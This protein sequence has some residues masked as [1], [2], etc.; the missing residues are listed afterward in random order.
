[1]P[2]LSK[3]NLRG[4]GIE[5][6]ENLFNRHGI[7]YRVE[8]GSLIFALRP[9]D[10]NP[11]C[12]AEKHRDGGW[13]DFGT[14][15]TGDAY[16]LIAK[17]HNL[18]PK[19]DFQRIL[20]LAYNFLG[21][22][23]PQDSNGSNGHSANGNGSGKKPLK[24]M[25]PEPTQDEFLAQYGLEKSDFVKANAR[26]QD[27]VYFSDIGKEVRAIIYDI[28]L[29]DGRTTYK[30][31]S[32]GR[33]TGGSRLSTAIKS[34]IGFHKGFF[35][36]PARAAGKHLVIAGGEEKRMAAE[37]AG[38]IAVCGANGE[39]KLQAETLEW[40]LKIAPS[41]ITIAFDADAPGYK[42]TSEL[43]RQLK[44]A[45]YKG[46]VRVISWPA[47]TPE[48]HDINDILKA[49]GIIGVKAHINGA[50][51][52]NEEEALSQE[53]VCTDIANAIRFADKFHEE[54]TFNRDVEHW[55]TYN[56]RH[57]TRDVGSAKAMRYATKVP[58]IILKEAGKDPAR[59]DMLGKWAVK[60]AMLPRLKALLEIARTDEKIGCGSDD[61]DKNH[62]DF[63]VRNGTID[64]RTGELR[65]HS[66]DDRIT[67][68]GNALYDPNADCPLWKS[69][70]SQI[71]GGNQDLIAFLQ[72]AVGYAMTGLTNEQCLFFLYGTGSNGKTTFLETIA[73]L[74]GDYAQAGRPESFLLDEHGGSTGSEARPDLV[75]LVGAR[76]V[77][78]TEVAKGRRLDEATVKALTG[79]DTRLIRDLYKP[80]FE[81]KPTLKLFM[82]ANH[83]PEIHG[84]DE[85]IWRRIHMIPFTVTFTDQQ[86]DE[87]LPEKLREEGPGILNWA[88]AGAKA[89]FLQKLD[90]PKLVKAA[91]NQYREES[92]ILSGFLRERCIVGNTFQET[93]AS[94]YAA[95]EEWCKTVGEQAVKQKTF[96]SNLKEKGF[97]NGRLNTGARGWFGIRLRK[98]GEG[99]QREQPRT[100][101]AQENHDLFGRSS[102]G[103]PMNDGEPFPKQTS[104]SGVTD[105]WDAWDASP[106]ETREN[107]VLDGLADLDGSPVK[108]HTCARN[109][110]ELPEYASKSVNASNPSYSTPSTS[111]G[112]TTDPDLDAEDLAYLDEERRAIMDD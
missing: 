41:E 92:D 81:W 22:P 52:F 87:R 106:Q 70:L 90:P 88:L 50:I 84:A 17:L 54:L 48:K 19:T 5:L 57:W 62:L 61:F 34:G 83:K 4:R 14:E 103:E 40:L 32:F 47:G 24:E 45:E 8:A 67:K 104:E 38:F 20:E 109:N 11:S 95:Y 26:V 53:L 112:Y 110:K 35:G 43:A 15:E 6:L 65:P 21:I 66:K 16:S 107:G 102:T 55:L 91:T 63:N 101:P 93:A 2:R 1:M 27:R 44:G 94:L 69:F 30:A 79:Q 97:Q 105:T 86:K 23:I 76:F 10:K 46:I 18:N 25:G 33:T 75:A 56:S 51:V 58:E 7:T 60:T 39:K 29:P 49:D 77:L 31:K 98:D 12:K 99:P 37:K 72:R 96:G 71:F 28:L 108:S 80:A 68:I 100:A 59:M 111:P 73:W 78:L 3:D 85:G 42:A 9:E 36:D 82:A 13:K 64:L 74:F 89:W